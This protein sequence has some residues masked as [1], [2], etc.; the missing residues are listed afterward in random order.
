MRTIILATTLLLLPSCDLP[1]DPDETFQRVRG[2]TMRVGLTANPPW[3][4]YEDDQPRG[5]E[6]ALVRQFAESLE[7]DIEWTNDSEAKL[8]E[9]LRDGRLD[10]VIGGL[11]DE[12]PWTTHAGFTQPYVTF[13]D[14][15]HVMAVKRGENRFLLEFDRFLQGR[16]GVIHQRVDAEAAR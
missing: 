3:T 12:S 1:R 16:R 9:H 7:A 2:A 8:M 14:K 13:A 11:D 15:P 10:L 6:V 4:M 5:I